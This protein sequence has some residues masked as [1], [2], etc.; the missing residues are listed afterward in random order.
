MDEMEFTEAESNMHDLVSAPNSIIANQIRLLNINN[1]KM[2][3]S[4]KRR[5]MMKRPLLR[6]VRNKLVLYKDARWWIQL[7]IFPSLCSISFLLNFSF[8]FRSMW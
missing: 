5:S 3:Q 2:R 7:L 6:K 1:I 4:T 8:Q